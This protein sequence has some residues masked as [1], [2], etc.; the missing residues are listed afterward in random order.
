MVDAAVEIKYPRNQTA[1]PSSTQ[2]SVDGLSEDELKETVNLER[3][4][5]KAD[6][7]ELEALGDGYAIT[8][9]FL[10]C[11]QY[12][13]LRRGSSTRERHHLLADAALKKIREMCDETAVLYAYPG[14]SEWLVSP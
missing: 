13:I 4:G 6:L 1:M 12:D 10:L 8:P 5:I 3:L 9:Y 11:S 7:K 2:G 14:D